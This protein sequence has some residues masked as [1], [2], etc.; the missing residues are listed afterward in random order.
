VATAELQLDVEELFTA[1]D[2]K[3]RRLKMT[4]KQ[5][6]EALG[7]SPCAVTFWGIGGRMSGDSVLR[8]CSWLGVDIKRF[9]KNDEAA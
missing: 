7:V 8:V 3:R 6:A 4:R 5:V 1:I 2:R 9:A